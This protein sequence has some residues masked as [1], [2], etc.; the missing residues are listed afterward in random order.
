MCDLIR[1]GIIGQDPAALQEIT[2]A[3]RFRWLPAE[4]ADHRAGPE[5]KPDCSCCS[6]DHRVKHL[7]F[8]ASLATRTLTAMEDT[9]MGKEATNLTHPSNAAPADVLHA[10]TIQSQELMTTLDATPNLAE[11]IL[12]KARSG[13]YNDRT[14]VELPYSSGYRF[15]H[16]DIGNHNFGESIIQ[17]GTEVESL[18]DNGNLDIN[19][20]Y[21]SAAM[22]EAQTGM[23][24]LN[25]EGDVELLKLL[26][27]MEPVD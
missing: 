2:E 22:G 17:S 25:M 6:R 5:G 8:I 18:N 15:G 13:S 19:D 12:G 16:L 24:V 4:I 10:R 11:K 14:Q 26:E 23:G 20:G 3:I 7:A 9:A 1:S 21:L 27:L